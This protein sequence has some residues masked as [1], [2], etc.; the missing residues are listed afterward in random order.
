LG[1]DSGGAITTLAE[2]RFYYDPL[3][4]NDPNE[5][6]TLGNLTARV[7]TLIDP[8]NP[9][10]TTVS[11]VWTYGNDGHYGLP[12]TVSDP[13]QEGATPL[14]TTYTYDASNTFPASASRGGLATTLTYGVPSH[15]PRG[16][17]L[18]HTKTDSNLR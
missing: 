16:L 13:F 17:G 9:P 6:L 3:A 11:T 7:D 8:V 4:P 5:P 14:V 1:F 2:A 15:V 12:L 18:V 10:S